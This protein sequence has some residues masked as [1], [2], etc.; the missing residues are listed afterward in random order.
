MLSRAN[1]R[2]WPSSMPRRGIHRAL[3]IVRHSSRLSVPGYNSGPERLNQI[4]DTLMH[5]VYFYH[6]DV[7][8]TVNSNCT[9]LPFVEN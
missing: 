5:H 9:R 1:H 6:S 8:G 3:T 7:D 4:L 2:F